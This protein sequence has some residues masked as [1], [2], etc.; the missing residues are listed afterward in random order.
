MVSLQAAWRFGATA[1]RERMKPAEIG[2]MLLVALWLSCAGARVAA[3]PAEPSPDYER[4]AAAVDELEQRLQRVREAVDQ[5]RF[6]ADE[7]VF[8]LS[9]DDE[10]I[11]AFVN[12]QIAFNP[13]EGLLRGVAGTLQSRAG[14]SL[15]QSL[16]LAYLLKSAGLDARVVRGELAESEAAQLLA[17]TRRAESPASLD[18]I[19]QAIRDQF[20]DEAAEAGEPVDVAQTPLRRRADE[21]AE[22]LARELDEAGSGPEAAAISGALSSTLQEYFWVEHRDGPGRD[23]RAAHPAFGGEPGF[24]PDPL[25]YMAEEIPERYHHTL[26]MEAFLRQRRL[27]EYETHPLMAAFSRPVANLHGAV[28]S[29]RNHPGGL[30]PET[31][32]DPDTELDEREILT[33]VFGDRSAPGAMAFDLKGRVIDPMA[34][35]SEVG[36][37][38]G[39]FSALADNMEA[40]TGTV[41]N[42]DDPTQVLEIDSMWLE[43]T[44]ESPSGDRRTQRRYLLPPP[45]EAERSPADSLWP[46]ISEYAYVVN[47]GDMPL[48]YVADRYLEAGIAGNETYKALAHELL[49]PDEGTPLPDA[50]LPQDFGP[51]ALYEIMDIDPLASAE[52]V[53]VRHRPAVIGLK[54]GLRDGDT[55]FS[56]VDIVFNDVLMLRREARSLRH[57]PYAALR[58]GVWETAVETLP[59]RLRDDDAVTRTN[60]MTVLEQARAQDIA[61]R[62]LTGNDAGPAE[63]LDMD[64][65][66]RAMLMQDLERGFTVVVP[67]RTPAGQTLTAWWRVDPVSGTTLGMTADG[68][69]QDSIE[70]L[71]RIR[72]ISFG[73]IQAARGLA[74]CNRIGGGVDKM[75]CLIDAH[76]GSVAGLGF[77]SLLGASVGTAGA[78]VFGIVDFGMQEAAEAAFVVPDTNVSCARNQGTGW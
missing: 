19:R 73:L 40:A 71:I 56:A 68:H 7:L 39:L 42:P 60:T 49:R 78:A 16:L 21:A 2:R 35:G 61:L 24:E 33:P 28:L 6:D 66:A 12:E 25:E 10:A 47:A 15:D 36:G 52:T 13:Y 29:Y 45:G 69:G 37:A 50:D 53:P 77:G 41:D 70:Y 57:D 75:C 67:E 5:T 48:D 72:G 51:L 20:G 34:L 23:W 59:A 43:L 74:V 64:G 18:R 9:F 11:V 1:D 31:L 62:V 22:R 58:R 44:S 4:L 54:N 27:D 38:A 17:E 30:T 55:A 63:G 76:I 8:D 26:T 3:Q 46:L 32:A 65:A 14:N